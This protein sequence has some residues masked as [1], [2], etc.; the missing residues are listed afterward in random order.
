MDEHKRECQHD[1][2]R[3]DL[4]NKLGLLRL[5]KGLGHASQACRGMGYS[6][7]GFYRFRELHA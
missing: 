4:K 6:R 7:D 2:R 3:K 5:A 1:K